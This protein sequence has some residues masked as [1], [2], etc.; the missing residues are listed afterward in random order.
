[1]N[2]HLVSAGFPDEI[3]TSRY[4]SGFDECIRD[5]ALVHDPQETQSPDALAGSDLN[6]FAHEVRVGNNAGSRILTFAPVYW[7]GREPVMRMS[8][9]LLALCCQPGP[10]AT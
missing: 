3:P 1:M 6:V 8:T 2:A 9:S 4:K 7:I 10:D 5:N